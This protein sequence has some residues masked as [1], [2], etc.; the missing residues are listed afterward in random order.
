MKDQDKYIK[1]AA[2]MVW[3]TSTID[4]PKL[5][6]CKRLPSCKKFV[7]R[8][9]AAGGKVDRGECIIAAA[10]RELQEETGLWVPKSDLRLID[11]HYEDEFKCFVFSTE[12]GAYRFSDVKN[13]EPK[14]HTKWQL[15]TKEEALALP[16]LMPA[17]QRILSSG[18]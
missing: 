5:M 4:K 16:T 1:S 9:G 17:L 11:S 18:A 8:W 15:F 6:L 2:V 13:P 3:F 7:G 12:I 14:K 10:Q